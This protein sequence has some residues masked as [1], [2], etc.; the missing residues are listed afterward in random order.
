M[1]LPS[2]A[3]SELRGR[4]LVS[5]YPILSKSNAYRGAQVAAVPAATV[6]LDAS[7]QALEFALGALSERLAIACAN[8]SLLDPP[9][10]ATT[11]EAIG[12]VAHALGQVKQLQHQGSTLSGL[13][14]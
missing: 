12:K 13:I 3:S 5:I 1:D 7:V 11:A 2:Q 14:S 8:P 4:Q 9:S 6:P 10:V